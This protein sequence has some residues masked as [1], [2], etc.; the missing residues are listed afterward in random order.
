MERYLTACGGDTRKA[1]TLYRYNLQ[2]SQEMFTIVSCFEVALRNAID[3]KL[4]ENLGEE[5]LKD[6]ITA[7]SVFTQPI[8]RKTRD[9]ISPLPTVNCNRHNRIPTRNCWQKWSLES[10]SICSRQFSIV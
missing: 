6:S 9:I 8:L 4:T 1:M 5:W 2:I 7:N 10:G 3:R